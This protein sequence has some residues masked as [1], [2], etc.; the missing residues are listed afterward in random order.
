[1][2]DAP[3]ERS[4]GRHV[5]EAIMF[6]FAVGGL[7]G[8]VDAAG[9]V[10]GF[11]RQDWP[12]MLA[13]SLLLSVAFYLPLTLL[14]TLVL[15]LVPALRRD[16]RLEALRLAFVLPLGF[17]FTN[18]NRLLLAS[19]MW[20]GG[21]RITIASMT[22]EDA[23]R[24][25]LLVAL[26]AVIIG[27]LIARAFW[28]RHGY[29]S[30]KEYRRQLR[31][32]SILVAL[33]LAVALYSLTNVNFDLNLAAPPSSQRQRSGP[34][35]VVILILDTV[36]GDAFSCY[37]AEGGTTPNID[38]LASQSTL[39]SRAISPGSWTLPSH[40]SIFTGLA[41][42]EHGVSWGNLFL[43]DQFTTLA[44]RLR[45]AGYR[46]VSITCNSM[47]APSGNFLQGFDEQYEPDRNLH[48][49]KFLGVMDV[50]QA[51]LRQPLSQWLPGE[52]GEYL[53][54][55]GALAANRLANRT[56]TEAA[57]SQKPLLLFVNYME[58]HLPYVPPRPYRSHLAPDQFS[59]SYQLDQHHQKRI[60][61][62]VVSGQDTFTPAQLNILRQLNRGTVSYLDRRVGELVRALE[63]YGL[64][65]DTLLVVTSDHGDNIGEHNL[66]GHNYCLYQTLVHVPLIIH[67]PGR[68]APGRVDAQVQTTDLY[69]TILAAC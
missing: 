28:H 23:M 69:P 7:F 50:T 38:R 51:I 30:S 17:Y 59:E 11:G 10:I 18:L 41:V 66:L 16:G 20:L 49:Y 46:T 68:L 62:F 40:S 63:H 1:M 31:E 64:S 26:F 53:T 8:A 21:K 12:Q 24:N 42:S 22:N 32:Q 61:P 5:R 27:V 57:E 15:A 29:W 55:R 60:W 44:E 13:V 47:L 58:A 43:E 14:I 9:A 33:A 37:G 52:W 39:Y 48:H 45:D 34:P 67:F 2:M 19:I 6:G 4:I 36:R 65:E 54:D 25:S 56:L 35:N 3:I